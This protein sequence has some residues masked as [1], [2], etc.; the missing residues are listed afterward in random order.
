M[1]IPVILLPLYGV[2]Q[3]LPACV[4]QS[5]TLSASFSIENQAYYSKQ[6]IPVISLLILVC[7]T[8]QGGLV[9]GT[10]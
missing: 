8:H 7:D 10:C 5:E 3:F 6:E 2:G 1:Y 4:L 9:P